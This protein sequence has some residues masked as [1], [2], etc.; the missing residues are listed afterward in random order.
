MPT[1]MESLFDGLTILELG[2]VI[3]APFA[4]SLMGDFEP[5]SSRLR[6]PVVATCYAIRVRPKMG[7][8]CGGNP[9]PAISPALRSTCEPP[10][11]S[12]REKK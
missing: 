4:A 2:H 7:S 11:A 9:L 3:A 6:I 1:N 10:R 5:R 8:I 12:A